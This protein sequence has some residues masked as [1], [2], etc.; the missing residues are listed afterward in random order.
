MALTIYTGGSG[1]GKS[2]TLLSRIIEESIQYPQKN[3]YVIV[4]EQSTMQTQKDLVRMHPKHGIL[5]IDVLS[6]NR[7]AYR[8]FHETGFR[9]E[10]L[11]EEIGKTFLLEKIALEEASNLDYFGKTLTRQENLAEMKAI[12]SELMLYG[13]SPEQLLGGIGEADERNPFAMKTKDVSYLYRKFLDRM[14][15]SYMTSEEVP[16]KL[17]ELVPKSQKIQ[18]SVIALDGFTGFTPI[19]LKLITRLMALAEEMYVTLTID[20]KEDVYGSY[21]KQ[22]LFSLSH[23]TF[24]SLKMA[25]DEAHVK[26]ERIIPIPMEHGRFSRSGEL[27]FLE[28]TVFRQT[29]HTW[30][31]EPKD[32][33][34]MVSSNPHDEIEEVARRISA[35]VR[36]K[37]Y[38]Y[39]DIA[40]V[41]GDLPS[42]DN[43][44]RQTFQ[45]WEIPYFL[46]EK[47]S[48]L[49]NPFIEYLRAALEVCADGFQYDGMFRML[50]SGMTDFDREAVEHL[51]NYCLGCGIRGKKRWNEPFYAHFRG[52][53]P[54]E[55]PYLEALR[56]EIIALI[57]PLA[58]VFAKRGSTVREK[59]V[60]L[61]EFCVLS[62]AEEKLKAWEAQYEREGRNALV[63]EYAQV[64]PYVMN[65]LDKLV[66]VLGEETISQRDYQ[67]LL[68]AGFQEARIAIIPPGADRVLV[69]DMERSRLADIKVLFFIGVN[70]GTIP[71]PI[72]GGGIFSDLDRERLLK[73]EI[74]LK[75]TAR[76]AMY[77]ERF[78][79]YLTLTKPS[80]MLFLSYTAAN[81]A[82]DAM[83]PAYLI[84]LMRR[85][86]PNIK[87]ERGE[88]CLLQKIERKETA[89]RLLTD[90]IGLL[91]EKALDMEYLELFSYYQH[92]PDYDRRINVLLEAAEFEKP[93]DQ[94]GRAA[95]EALYGKN[96][97]N[98]ATRLEEFCACEFGHFLK[99]GL[100]LKDRP[101][102]AFSGLEMGSLLH[103]SLEHFAGRVKAG[104]DSWNDLRD[105]PDK[106]L[107]Y[108]LESMKE[109][110]EEDGW[111]ILHDS[112]RNEYQINRM[113]RLLNTSV[114]ALADALAAGDFT[115]S[116]VEAAFVSPE[117]LDAMNLELP[118]GAK[119]TLTGRIDRIDTYEE[120]GT[121]YVKIIDYK[122]GNTEF[123]L[124]AVY[125][126]LQMQLIVYLNAALEML[127][128]EGKHP[129]PAGIFYY[130]IKDPLVSYEALES[131]EDREKRILHELMASG[132]VLDDS[133]VLHHLDKDLMIGE[134]KSRVLP[135]GYTKKGTYTANSSVLSIEQFDTV[136]NYIRRKIRDAAGCILRG[137][138]AI[139][140]YAYK[141]KKACDYCLYRGICGFDRRIPGYDYRKLLPMKPAEV[142]QKMED[143]EDA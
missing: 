38:R 24:R 73:E 50:K 72:S 129:I 59:T 53:D 114:W 69:G 118:N 136:E 111:E 125:H 43:Y 20:P 7:L 49:T 115:L 76:D 130:R 81:A 40:I 12:L 126:G 84:D 6:F 77:I 102:F 47:R 86:F 74:R 123:D 105:Q 110:V 121:T 133:E 16:D 28:E 87:T 119:M 90:G 139:N 128:K 30:K 134:G 138:A 93:T 101:K 2:Y 11:L 44:V 51:E 122:T 35:L 41:T 120:D 52:Q 142:I 8:V 96:L 89:I 79:L 109:T 5:N 42:Y 92:D 88:E 131:E 78:Y 66:D 36:E 60:A 100:R 107:Q 80:D 67:A 103:R 33:R 99:Y 21:H 106:R 9:R 95:A 55:V 94:I 48:L 64:Y 91:N 32:V 113:M 97:R 56:K 98:S 70:E 63:R 45:E 23:E 22:D 61:Y 3:F 132:I 124:N 65:F 26:L 62:H 71:K 17:C 18:G 82:G 39:R 34:L 4:P 116:D 143:G 108:A 31:A 141:T 127:Q 117:V 25:A 15:G 13:V 1:Y 37:G 54:A 135:V 46:D 137:D 58:E 10:E 29:P 112:A 140:P 68:E 75:P 85:L 19:Q 14:A 57:G 83:R 27:A 104:G